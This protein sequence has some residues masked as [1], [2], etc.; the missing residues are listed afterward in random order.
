MS[1]YYGT[2]L[3]A[4]AYFAER[5]NTDAWD[6]T[7]DSDDVTHIKGLKQ[8]TR[9]IDALNF[10]GTKTDED[11]ELQFPRDDDSEVPTEIKQACFEEALSLLDGSDSELEF[12][13]LDMKSQ[14]Y[15]NIRSTYDRSSPP[16]HIIAGFTSVTAWRKLKPYLRDG[17]NIELSRVN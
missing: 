9:A 11:Q 6:D 1:A 13:N 3:E 8:A 4:N 17:Q 2:I 12:S 16:L 10:Y 7:V 15:A 5:L 14:G